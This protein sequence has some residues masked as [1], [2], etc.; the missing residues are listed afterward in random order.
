MCAPRAMRITTSVVRAT[1]FLL[2]EICG[3]ELSLQKVMQ[4]VLS[5]LL[6][7]FLWLLF[8]LMGSDARSNATSC[9][10]MEARFK[11]AAAAAASSGRIL[12]TSAASSKSSSCVQEPETAGIA[13]ADAEGTTETVRTSSYVRTT[14]SHCCC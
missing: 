9:V 14:R 6:S 11:R 13:L 2:C 5:F 7:F 3:A 12:F 1:P 4:L 8:L 10:M